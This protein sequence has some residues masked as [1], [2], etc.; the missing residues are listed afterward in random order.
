M[1]QISTKKLK[2]SNVI[3]FAINGN[4]AKSINVKEF[5]VKLR[6]V[7]L[8][9]MD[10]IYVYKFAIKLFNAVYMFVMISVT[11]IH[12]NLVE[13]IQE[14]HFFVPVALLKLILLFNVVK[15]SQLVMEIARKFMHVG[16]NVH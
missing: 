6:K 7:F 5:A 9:Q 4:L 13:Y 10:I 8:I 15:Y 16:T 11:S 3:K 12:V 2:I 14:N 1:I